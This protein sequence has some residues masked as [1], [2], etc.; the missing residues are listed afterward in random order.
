MEYLLIGIVAVFTLGVLVL[1]HELG[2]FLVARYFNIKVLEFGFGLPPRIWGKK[3]GD[4]LYSLN[5]LPFGG[6]VHLLGE[7]ESDKT[8]LKDKHSFASQ[9][10]W[11]RIAV[12]VAG[13]TMNLILAMILYTVVLASSNFR[14]EIPLLSDHQFVGVVQTNKSAILVQEIAA[15]SPAEL[16]GLRVGD[17]ITALNGKELLSSEILIQTAKTSGG[18]PLVLTID[19]EGIDQAE[20]VSLIPRQNPPEGQGPLGVS[21]SGFRIAELNYATPMQRIFVGPIHS[22]NLA[23]YSIDVLSGLIGTSVAKKDAAAISQGVSGPVGILQIIGLIIKT[24]DFKI[25]LDFMAA[26]SLN[27][28]VVNLLPFPGLDG[29][30]LAFFIV[31]L[32][33]RKKPHPTVEKYIHSIGLVILLSMIILVTAS[34]LQKIF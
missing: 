34:D 9:N 33:T 3:F 19:R 11:K 1:I 30:R 13:V 14:T 22:Y 20:Q 8:V 4:T 6:F 23:S 18:T 26:L 28:A 27:L 7:D 12:V 25:Y 2:H 10:V 32:I 31:E 16:T 5:W 17:R 24:G 29:G 21:L 15:S